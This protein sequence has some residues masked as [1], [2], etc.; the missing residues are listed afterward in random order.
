MTPLSLQRFRF[1]TTFLGNGAISRN[2]G[3]TLRGGF[4]RALRTVA[5]SLDRETCEAC[6]LGQACAYGYIFETP[7]PGSETV[8]RNYPQ[9]PHPF[10]FEPNQNAKTRVQTS[11]SLT[12][13]LVVVGEAIRYLAHFFLAIEQLGR[14]GLGGDLVPFQVDHVTT[15][16]GLSVFEHPRQSCFAMARLEELMLEPGA[17]RTATFEIAFRT[18]ARITVGGR[19]AKTPTLLDVVKALARR[20]FLLRH[21]HCGRGEEP[22]SDRFLDAA[23]AARC[24]E[25]RL[26]WHDA[27]RYSTRQKRR[28]PIGGVMGRMVFEGD[29]G[30][31]EPL[32]RAGEYVHVGKN[33]TFGLGKFVVS[34]GGRP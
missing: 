33:A 26:H 16:A 27:D 10:I 21:F 9:A 18:P 6:P 2:W 24:L 25:T 30:I 20:V 28:V 1:Q 22:V 8:M 17:S 23:R 31:L 32:L 3:P 15:E 19:I 7:I 13:S 34:E 14:N 4:G 5:C 12:H 29:F 11:E